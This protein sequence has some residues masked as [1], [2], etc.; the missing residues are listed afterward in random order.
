MNQAPPKQP[1]KFK[2]GSERTPTRLLFKD[3][4]GGQLPLGRLAP[5]TTNGVGPPVLPMTPR[6]PPLAHRAPSIDDLVRELLHPMLQLW[7]DQ[8]LPRL[9]ERLVREEVEL[10]QRKPSVTS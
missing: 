3:L 1:A 8:N 9:V 2:L 6:Q 10:A 7:L 4:L 5:L